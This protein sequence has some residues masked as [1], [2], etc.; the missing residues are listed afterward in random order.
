[1]NWTYSLSR[2]W[3]RYHSLEHCGLHSYSAICQIAQ[4]RHLPR[5]ALLLIES[6]VF[7]PYF[8]LNK[9]FPYSLRQSCCPQ[10]IRLF[11]PL[12][13]ALPVASDRLLCTILTGEY[14]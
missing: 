5:S 4:T 12:F 3:T 7:V 6:T 8:S 9:A 14:H 13:G 10:T 2:L 1:M 11:R